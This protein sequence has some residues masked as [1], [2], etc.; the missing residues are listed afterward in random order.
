LD[1]Q[2]GAGLSDVWAAISAIS[3]AVSALVV[4]GAA[5][6][7][8][9]QVSE[10]KKARGIQSLLAVHEQ[11]QSSELNLTRRRL[12]AGELG[13]V[14]E[15][16]TAEREQLGNLLNQLELIGVLTDQGLIDV[17]LVRAVFPAVPRTVE[18][19]MPFILARRHTNP[20]YAQMS[21]KLAGLYK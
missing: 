21:E 8:A 7:A 4:L 10:L 2:G 15:L 14:S 18:R 6:Y 5:A 11:Y 1:E 19:A 20:Q 3:A 16:K 17:E 12:H 13:D 9:M